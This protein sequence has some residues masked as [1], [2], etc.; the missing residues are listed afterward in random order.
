MSQ[1]E[2]LLCEI[3]PLPAIPDRSQELTTHFRDFLNSAKD[4]AVLSCI[5]PSLTEFIYSHTIEDR[6][7][8]Y[9]FVVWR[10]HAHHDGLTNSPQFGSAGK[11]LL[12]NVF[13]RMPKSPAPFYV[14]IS[15]NDIHLLNAQCFERE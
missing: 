8:V 7:R 4:V 15:S 2:M 10:S 12:E 9:S 13:P 3:I 6:N 11:I 14:P 1:P 5:E